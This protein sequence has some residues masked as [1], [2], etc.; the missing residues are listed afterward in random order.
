MLLTIPEII[1]KHRT[2]IILVLS[3]LV[4]Q[5]YLPGPISPESDY[6]VLEDFQKYGNYPF[7][8]WSYVDPDHEAKTV[9]RI[10]EENGTKFL[11]ASTVKKSYFVQIGKQVNQNSA[12]KNRVSWDIHSYPFISW[13][14][15]V[16]VI[17]KG[18]NESIDD[19]ND[20]AA[21]IYVIFQRTKIPFAGW[22]KQ[23]ANWIKYVWSST[24]PVGTVY[25]KTIKKFGMTLYEGRYVVVASG[26]KDLGKWITFKRNVLAD[27]R[28]YFGG[29]PPGNPVEIAILTDSNTTHTQAEADYDNIRIYRK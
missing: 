14:W 25:S 29:N 26:E 3:V 6:I 20:S 18:A 22:Q 9:Y 21:S 1:M 12:G 2:V 8:D 27:Y 23:P 5:I 28:S 16:N 19:F 10:A 4:F 11:R 15:R 17:P 13:D 7:P 24:L